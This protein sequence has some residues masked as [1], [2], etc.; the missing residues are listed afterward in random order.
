MPLQTMRPITVT[1]ALFVALV[2]LASVASAF[3]PQRMK[4]SIRSGA[5]RVSSPMNHPFVPS[6][7]MTTKIL[8]LRS[9][10]QSTSHLFSSIE[11]NNDKDPLTL[12]SA[13]DEQVQQKAFLAI[14]AGVLGGSLVF[15][16]LYDFLEVTL[17]AAIFDPFYTVLPYVL[18][19]AF[20]SAGI[21]HFALE[22]TFTA[23]VPPKGSWVSL[24][25]IPAPGA[26]ALGLTYAQYHFFWSGIA[27]ILAGTS[28]IVTTAAANGIWPLTAPFPAL[29]AAALWA[30]T[31][32]VTPANV[33]MYTHDQVVPRIPALPYPWR[34]GARGCLQC[35]LLAV[36]AKLARHAP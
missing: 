8:S 7:T 18:S 10:F 1:Q 21:A 27:E 20:I 29:P 32:A 25:R 2:L 16:Q 9:R 13:Q 19:L 11:T 6:K 5:L 4:S 30:L 17:P 28:L 33:Y 31:A 24:W 3:G 23:F 36:F 12:I 26:E 35:A 15:L 34:H 22:D 14:C